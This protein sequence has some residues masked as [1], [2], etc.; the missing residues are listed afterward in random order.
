MRSLGLVLWLLLGAWTICATF[1]TA[2]FSFAVSTTLAA[3]VGVVFLVAS[4]DRWLGRRAAGA[5]GAKFPFSVLAV[6][7]A[8]IV[9][10]WYCTRVPD[11][12]QVWAADHAQMPMVRIDGDQVRVK[13]VRNFTWRTATDFTPAYYDR[14]F[15]VS[16]INSMY[17]LIVPLRGID[18]VAHVFVCFGFSDGQ[19]VAVSVEGRRVEGRPYR[20]IPS[21]FQQF[22][23][24]YVVGDERDVVGKRG[25]I[26]KH[27]VRFY[28]AASTDERKR[29]LFVDMMRRANHLEYY[30]EFYH[31]LTNNC[32]NNIT[33]HM[34][35][36]GG[37]PLP[38]DLRL[39]LTGLSDRLAYD[40]GFIDTDLPFEKAREV[41]LIDEWMR[42][43]P[44]DETFS[45]RL[46]DMLNQRVAAARR[47]LGLAN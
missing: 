17:Y 2:P 6:L 32:M 12:N 25:A 45:Q 8:A 42:S 46:R 19:F 11:P 5:T 37:R 1:F 27:P 18:L 36:L 31:L 38:S 10:A 40:Y 41:F 34:R 43:A 3:V 29:A 7:I 16:K 15:D 33:D 9:I 20:I 35:M 14:T 13:N 24:I 26:W 30:P 23:L 22:Q 28:P 39:L 4:R 47:E 44:L 21:M